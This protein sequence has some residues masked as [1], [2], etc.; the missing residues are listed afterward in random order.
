MSS[1]VIPQAEPPSPPSLD[2]VVGRDL[3]VAARRLGVAQPLGIERPYRA[4]RYPSGLAAGEQHLEVGRR[5]DGLSLL[6]RRID[7][8]RRQRDGPDLADRGTRIVGRLGDGGRRD[9]EVPIGGLFADLEFLASL[10]HHLVVRGVGGGGV[11]HTGT[12]AWTSC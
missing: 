10:L 1:P 5:D 2:L 12:P 11:A 3:P 8:Q 7:A 6:G 9:G 4:R